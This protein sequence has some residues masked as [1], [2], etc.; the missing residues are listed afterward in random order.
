ME[1]RVFAVED[2]D[3]SRLSQFYRVEV[4]PFSGLPFYNFRRTSVSLRIGVSRHKAQE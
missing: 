3:S 2:R 1:I 4:R